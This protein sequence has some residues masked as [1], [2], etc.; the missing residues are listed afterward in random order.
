MN[1]ANHTVLIYSIFYGQV[2][3]PS[4]NL[5]RIAGIEYNEALRF[6]IKLKIAVSR[7]AIRNIDHPFIRQLIPRQ[8]HRAYLPVLRRVIFKNNYSQ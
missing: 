5:N 7:P 1:Q 3:L 6:L 2:G 8:K 4:R